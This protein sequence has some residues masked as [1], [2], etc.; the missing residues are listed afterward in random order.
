[1]DHFFEYF[2]VYFSYFIYGF[3]FLFVYRHKVLRKAHTDAQFV[4]LESIV[5][6]YIIANSLLLIPFS[7]GP[8]WDRI[9]IIITSALLGYVLGLILETRWFRKGLDKLKIYDNG[10]TSPWIFAQDK[11]PYEI[12]ARYDNY[13]IRGFVYYFD[14]PSEN[15][16]AVV[17]GYTI[18]DK[19]GKIIKDYI[20]ES[21]I[22]SKEGVKETLVAAHDSNFK[23]S[24]ST[25]CVIDL[26]K[27]NL[28]QYLYKTDS[29]KRKELDVFNH[30]T[31]KKRKDESGSIKN[32]SGVGEETTKEE[33]VPTTI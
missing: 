15:S 8:V 10:V 5:W 7:K 1:M 23:Q 14:G 21:F 33:K 12:I 9:G 18:Y 17:G 19:D 20:P 11:T 13:S 30:W 29:D 4:L 28:V 25:M 31:A 16:K 26:S 24:A 32:Q 2:S 22:V 27:A 6:G 3:T